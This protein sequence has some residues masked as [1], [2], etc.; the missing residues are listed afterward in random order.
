MTLTFELATLSLFVAYCLVM[1][2]I[3]AKLFI[4][5]TIHEVMGQIKTGFTKFKCRLFVTLAF[6]L[7]TWF[8]FS[9]DPFVMM[10]TCA[11][12]FSKLTMHDKVMGQT[13]THFTET[14]AQS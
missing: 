2:I 10:L 6:D 14:H 8:L 13:R 1:M 12:L 9:T 3:C 4:N 5:P 7:E 11:K